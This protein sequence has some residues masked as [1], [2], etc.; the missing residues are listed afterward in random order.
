MNWSH[1]FNTDH[2]HWGHVDEALK[3]AKECGYKFMAWN[4]RVLQVHNG[5]NSGITVEDLNAKTVGS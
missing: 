3:A 5:W 1:V 2:K 4:G